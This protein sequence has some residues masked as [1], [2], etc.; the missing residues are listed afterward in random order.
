MA[1]FD[2]AFDNAFDSA[3]DQ[4]AALRAVVIPDESPWRFPQK[5][6]APRG[7]H[8]SGHDAAL[9]WFL[10]W[11]ECEPTPFAAH[12]LGWNE[13]ARFALE[14]CVLNGYVAR[15]GGGRIPAAWKEPHVRF[16]LSAAGRA[17][18]TRAADA[19][20]AAERAAKGAGRA[21]A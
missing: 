1:P 13:D 17:V 3:P 6:R 16:V 10:C 18:L 20:A 11:A 21:A 12:E 14:G 4:A 15:A 2:N 7:R 8:A 19:E 5:L 9:V